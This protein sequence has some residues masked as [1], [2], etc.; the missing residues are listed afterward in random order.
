MA[1]FG[2]NPQSCFKKVGTPG[3]FAGLIFSCTIVFAANLT[4]PVISVLDGDTIEVFTVLTRANLW[5]F[6]N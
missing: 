4:G 5:L 6:L 3:C 1:F 2:Y